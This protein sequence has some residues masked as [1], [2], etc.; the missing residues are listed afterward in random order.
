[1]LA[2]N[3]RA[4]RKIAKSS[5]DNLKAQLEDMFVPPPF[6]PPGKKESEGAILKSNSTVVRTE[7]S[8]ETD[9][10]TAPEVRR[11]PVQQPRQSRQLDSNE[12]N[13][14]DEAGVRKLSNDM[15]VAVLLLG[16]SGVIHLPYSSRE[17]W[18]LC[19]IL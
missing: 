13:L 8:M 7:T 17:P 19:L 2:Q 15:L 18:I 3:Q 10:V 5:Q 9:A 14:V 12:P 4:N 6:K 11:P 1:M 16:N